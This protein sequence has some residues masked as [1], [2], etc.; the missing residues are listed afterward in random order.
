MSRNASKGVYR[1]TPH[2]VP[3]EKVKA[4]T[5][6]QMLLASAALFWF[7]VAYRLFITILYSSFLLLMFSLR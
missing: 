7:M 6:P 3:P 1:S 2:P 4:K 5:A